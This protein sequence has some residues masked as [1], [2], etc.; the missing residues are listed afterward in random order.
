MQENHFDCSRVAKHVLILGLSGHVQSNPTEPAQSAQSSNSG[1]QSDFSQESVTPKS[2]CLAPRAS[3][4]QEKG[5]SE[6][7]PARIEAPQ[8]GSTRS[9][10]EAKWTSASVI[11]WTSE[12][13]PVKSIA[14]FLL[15]LFQGRK[16]QPNTTDGYRSAIVDKLGNSSIY[17]SKDE[18][19]T[20]LLDSFHRDRPKC[21]PSWN[22]SLV[23]HQLT[24][25]SF[26]PLKEASLK[27]LTLKTVFILALCS[28]K[29]RTESHAC[30]N[31]NIRHQVDWSKVSLYPSPSFL[32]KNQ[33]T[34]EGPDSV[35]PVVIQPWPQ[36][37]RSHS[38]LIGP[39]VRSEQ[40]VTI[41]TRPRA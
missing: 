30:Q 6:A 15:Y 17:V 24:K 12:H 23:F 13:P 22:L 28:G 4:I 32:S 33:L 8:R 38:S 1:L 27:H 37:W 41:W 21:I 3:A 18:N 19:L 20:H 7:E 31:K 9:V 14:D 11:R 34:K 16:L 2:P 40:C 36:L 5:F 10:Y 26:E 39:C 25:A 35:A 29:R